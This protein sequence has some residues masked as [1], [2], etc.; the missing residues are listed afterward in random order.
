M[1]TR[2]CNIQVVEGHKANLLA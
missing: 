1:V 2:S